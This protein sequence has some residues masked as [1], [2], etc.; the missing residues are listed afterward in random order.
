MTEKIVRVPQELLILVCDARKALLLKNVGPVA[1]PNLE[2]FEHLEAENRQHELIDSDEP[3]RRS[4]GG[5]HEPSGGPRSAMETRDVGDVMAAAFADK[6]IDHLTSLNRKSPLTGLAVFAPP[7]FLGLLRK[8]LHDK[9]GNVQTS[10]I[11]KHLSELP[12]AE[13]QNAVLKNLA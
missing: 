7:A 8:G 13:L 4:D 5:A 2:I 10:E 11:A 9:L 6:L 1:Q 12:V 3:G